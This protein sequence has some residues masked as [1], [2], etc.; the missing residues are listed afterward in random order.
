MLSKFEKAPKDYEIVDTT[1]NSGKWSGLSPFR[2]G[3]ISTKWGIDARNFENLWQYAK[4]YHEHCG[5]DVHNATLRRCFGPDKTLADVNVYP[6]PEYYRWAREGWNNPRAVRYPM[7][8]GA[9]PLFSWWEGRALGYIKARKAIY[10]PYYAHYVM[11]T[12][13]WQALKDR[14]QDVFFNYAPPIALRDYDGYNHIAQ[15]KTLTQV[16]NDPSKK[17]GHA[18]VLAALLSHDVSMCEWGYVH[19]NIDSLRYRHF[20]HD[21]RM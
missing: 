21:L 4:V 3:P 18:F 2:L 8:K 6:T 7:G 16:L 14:Y 9:A 20:D 5:G 19:V 10:A 1:S 13:A 17:M 15:G 12:D 11:Q